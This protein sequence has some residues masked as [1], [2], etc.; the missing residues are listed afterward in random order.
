[1]IT[2]Q[3]LISIVYVAQVHFWNQLLAKYILDLWNVKNRASFSHTCGRGI[4]SKDFL[5]QLF[6]ENINFLSKGET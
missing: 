1:M 4:T 5:L 3:L 6:P 2:F